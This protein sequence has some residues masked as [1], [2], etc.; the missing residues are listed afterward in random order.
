MK[1]LGILFIAM[2]MVSSIASAQK[3]KVKKE[4]LTPEQRA[5]KQTE[6][7]TKQLEL[8]PDQKTKIKEVITNKIITI[9]KIKDKYKGEK[10]KERNAELKEQRISFQQSMKDIL[11]PIQLEKWTKLRK[12]KAAKAKQNKAKAKAPAQEEESDDIF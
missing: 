1:K 11:T 6:I 3:G 10:S 2:M 4:Q 9:D 5:T 7:L 8:T 12:D